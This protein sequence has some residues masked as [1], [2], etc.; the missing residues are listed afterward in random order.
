[1]INRMIMHRCLDGKPSE[2]EMYHDVDGHV[3]TLQITDVTVIIDSRN[4]I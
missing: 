1:M 3:V 4:S 2:S